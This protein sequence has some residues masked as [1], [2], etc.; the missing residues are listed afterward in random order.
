MPIPDL[1]DRLRAEISRRL[2][3]HTTLN[4]TGIDITVLDLRQSPSGTGEE[5]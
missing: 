4:V 2:S 1:A 5:R 3:A